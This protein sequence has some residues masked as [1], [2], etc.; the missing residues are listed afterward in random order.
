MSTS[1]ARWYVEFSAPG[2]AIGV[3]AGAVV[4]GL[5]A[6]A[7][8]PPAWALASIVALGVPLAL[9]GGVYGMLTARG[10]AQPGVFA[11]AALLWFVGFPLSR[12]AHETMTPVLLGGAPTPPDDVVTFLAFQALVSMGFAFGFIWLY[13]RITP[14]WLARIR[15]HNPHAERV[16]ARYCAHAE[17]MWE[18]RERRRA[19]R[20]VGRAARQVVPSRAT[21]RATR[22]RRPS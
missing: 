20:Q 12:L 7:G 9:L 4:G 15:E 16:Y 8:H 6:L 18:A 1:E 2:A 11:P 17:A 5:A 21:G 14:P 10:L 13:E 3:I 22:S 19:R